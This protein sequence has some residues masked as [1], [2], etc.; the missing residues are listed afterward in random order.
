MDK[1]RDGRDT[2]EGYRT[3]EQVKVELL[4]VIVYYLYFALLMYLLLVP[5]I[6][7]KRINKLKKWI[8]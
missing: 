2:A 3:L 5:C 1:E 4:R 7:V 8:I 6:I